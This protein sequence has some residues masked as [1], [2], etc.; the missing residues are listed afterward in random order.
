MGVHGAFGQF[1]K[2]TFPSAFSN[3]PPEYM[4]YIGASIESV[5]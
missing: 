3:K 1:L 5:I 2:S 4:S